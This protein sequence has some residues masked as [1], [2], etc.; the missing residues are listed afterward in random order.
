[1]KTVLGIMVGVMLLLGALPFGIAETW[2]SQTDVN[3]AIVMDMIWN[4]DFTEAYKNSLIWASC[5]NA[6]MQ[7]IA[8]LLPI[9]LPIL[10]PWFQ[11]NCPDSCQGLIANC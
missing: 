10:I 7:V 2:P 3:N 5:T 4:N 1:M 8:I 11:Q 6:V 9:L